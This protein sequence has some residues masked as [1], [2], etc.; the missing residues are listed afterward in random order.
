MCR[1]IINNLFDLPP[2]EWEQ[3]SKLTN[4]KVE[5]IVAIKTNIHNKK[6]ESL[7]IKIDL[8]VNNKFINNNRNRINQVESINNKQNIFNYSNRQLTQT[9][10]KVLEKGLKY[11]IKNKK[12]DSY[13]I[14][15]RFEQLAQ[16]LDKLPAKQNTDPLLADTDSKAAC[17]KQLQ[18]MATEFI[19]LS[20]IARDN[21]TDAEHRALE[22]LSKDTTII[23]TKA[24]K[25]NAVVI[26]NKDDYLN[27]VH[28]LLTS[29]G[30][31][32]QL[33][34]DETVKRETRLH[35]YL[36]KLNK[37]DEIDDETYK[38]VYPCGSRAGVMYGLPK[39][40]K[41]GVPVRPIISA[42]GTYNFRLA[43]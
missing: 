41:E 15:A 39:I 12:V 20:K 31:F 32:N 9:E 37:D 23:I 16:S 42:C 43:K 24:D 40:H 33:N 28:S 34:G 35:N 1:K 4:T 30:K 13:E 10:T 29:G 18:T 22:E 3:L 17:M 2:E 14:L 36:L 7:G 26:Q 19:E 11:G 5:K 27:K 25:G 8:T 6:L 38:R 21:L